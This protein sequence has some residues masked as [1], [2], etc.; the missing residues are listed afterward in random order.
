MQKWVAVKVTYKELKA[1][2]NDGVGMVLD[3]YIALELVG[4]YK[5]IHVQWDKF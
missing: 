4:L 3:F 5:E 1:G 2:Y